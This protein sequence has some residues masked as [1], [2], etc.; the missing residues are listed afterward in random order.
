[1][2]ELVAVCHNVG[3]RTGP[4]TP[5]SDPGK[6][7]ANLGRL[8]R[9]TGHPHAIAVQEAVR[10]R[11]TI[12]GYQRVAIEHPGHPDD[13]GCQL[14]VRDDV[15]LVRARML[16]VGGPWWTGPRHGLRH[17]PKVFV[18]ATLAHHGQR[19]DVLSVH[20][21]WTGRQRRNMDTWR[22]E[23][24]ALVSWATARAGRGQGT[25]PVLLLGDWNARADDLKPLARAV[26]GQLAMAGIDGALGVNVAQLRAHRL[27]AVYGSDNHEPVVVRAAT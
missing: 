18:G 15:E 23:H 3:S 4:D 12:E 20:R 13:L 11:H 25:R 2:S 19:W 8:A 26:G 6:L 16:P 17:P 5:N 9:A 22:A 14:L 1:M 7:R 21:V 10:L 27:A 24:E